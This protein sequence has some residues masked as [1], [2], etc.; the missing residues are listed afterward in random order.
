MREMELWRD[1]L[2]LR[3]RGMIQDSMEKFTRDCVEMDVTPVGM[4]QAMDQ[5]YQR[6][7]QLVHKTLDVDGALVLDLSSFELVETIAPDGS[8][9][10]HYK[11]DPYQ[12]DEA[13]DEDEGESTPGREKP[14]A[15]LARADSFGPIPPIPVLGSSETSPA[16]ESRSKLVSGLEHHKLA[17]WLKE[18]PDGRIY[19]KVV[20]SWFKHM[21]PTANLAFAMIVPVFNVDRN[22]FALVCA[23]TCQR[24]FLEGYE[25]KY[26]RAI[27]LIILSAALK[28]R[29]TLADKAKAN[30]ISNISHELR[31]PLHGI[32][33]AGEL[34]A[35]T[36][37][38]V[39]QGGYL[40]T[41][42]ACGNS[43]IETVN[44][45]LDFTVSSVPYCRSA[46]PLR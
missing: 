38:T 44:H 7:A 17:E 9:D 43:L 1:K 13:V 35:D 2:H 40:E 42:Q 4:D 26:L 41:V 24:E 10:F 5:V 31:T 18:Y 39:Q 11:A 14:P 19:E 8:A 46:N 22:P 12:F 27:G 6:A 16:P 23:Y 3:R 36:K 29:L 34:L 28:R 30:F 32:L 20:P 37:L 25:L 15:F 45:V 21:I 33:V